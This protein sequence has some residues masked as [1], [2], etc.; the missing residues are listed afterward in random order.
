MAHEEDYKPGMHHDFGMTPLTWW[1]A[2]LAGPPQGPA[3]DGL[4]G[5]HALKS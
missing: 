4:S 2:A 1:L 3:T 5:A